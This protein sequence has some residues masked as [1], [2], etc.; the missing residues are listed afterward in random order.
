MVRRK[1]EWGGPREWGCMEYDTF[2]YISVYLMPKAENQRI[3][4]FKL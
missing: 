1:T 2:F 3:D 4:A